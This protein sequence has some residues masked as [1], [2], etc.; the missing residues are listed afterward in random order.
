[1][2]L[3]QLEHYT[4][5]TFTVLSNACGTSNEIATNGKEN[6]KS[7]SKNVTVAMKELFPSGVGSAETGTP[8]EGHGK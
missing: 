5:N 1:M 7:C 3:I 6:K 4:F 2:T 8:G